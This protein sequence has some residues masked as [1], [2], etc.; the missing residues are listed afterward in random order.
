[1]SGFEVSASN[2]LSSS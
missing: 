1:M 2:V